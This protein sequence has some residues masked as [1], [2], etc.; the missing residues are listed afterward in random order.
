M[1]QQNHLRTLEDA[2]TARGIVLSVH[3]VG[4]PGQIVSAIDAAKA[5]GAEALNVLGSPFLRASEEAIIARTAK[6]KFPAIYQFPELAEDGGLSGYGPRVEQVYRDLQAPMLVK[7]LKGVKPAD[8]PI[9]QP[10]RFE[11]VINLKTAKALGLTVPPLLLAR[12]DEV[13]E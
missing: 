9:E 10:T 13:I 5:E 3:S 4:E 7:L 8:L 2:A 1:T 6:L 12:A 11:L